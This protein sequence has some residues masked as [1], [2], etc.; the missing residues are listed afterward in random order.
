MLGT[1]SAYAW[2]HGADVLIG[3]AGSNMINTSINDIVGLVLKKGRSMKG[4][5]AR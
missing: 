3:E 1:S 5:E 4:T 2:P